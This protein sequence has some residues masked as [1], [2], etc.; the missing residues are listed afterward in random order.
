MGLSGKVALVTGGARGIG[1]SIAIKLAKEGAHIVI[2]DIN[3]NGALDTAKV[4]EEQGKE[5]IAVEGNV[6]IF[7]D[8]E[9]MVK[10]A[11][12][13][14]GRID[15]LINNA[16]VT[17]DSLL[18]RMKKEDWDFVLNVNLT[19]TFNCSKAV[20]KYMMKQKTGN[21]VNISSVVGVMGNVGQV[22]YASSKAGVIGLTKSMARELA[23]RGI[24][25]NAIAPGFIDTEMTRSLSEEARNRLVTQ[26]PL[27]R[28]G[29]P[30]DVANCVNFLVSDDADYITGQV[31][32]VNG[33]MLM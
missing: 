17:K 11:I 22:N 24:R 18:I 10:Q 2:S 26:I 13:K 33:G 3:L 21:V 16:G 15:I 23:P 28:L 14:F 12:D 20:A 31:I 8:V 30:D 25:V 5:S 4:I 1:R 27:T 32:H 7:S 6:S 9:A 19:G 29:T